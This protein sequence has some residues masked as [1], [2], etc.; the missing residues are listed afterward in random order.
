MLL[1]RIVEMFSQYDP[2]VREV[3]GNT[4]GVEQAHISEKA[5]RIGQEID[6]LIDLA[7]RDEI[8]RR[9][10]QSSQEEGGS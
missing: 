9:D 5:P 2:G 10:Q 6:D 7:A 4:L 3:V 8:K 1:D